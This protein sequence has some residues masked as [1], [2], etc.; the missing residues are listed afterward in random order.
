MELQP[1]ILESQNDMNT[2]DG[3]TIER[4]IRINRPDEGRGRCK[5][6]RASGR[7]KD[8]SQCMQPSTTPCMGLFPSSLSFLYSLLLR[9]VISQ[10]AA[11]EMIGGELAIG[12]V[13]MRRNRVCGGPSKDPNYDAAMRIA[14]NA[15]S[16]SG[17]GDADMARSRRR[18]VSPTCQ[19]NCYAFYSAM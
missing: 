3:A 14:K 11:V 13:S 19:Q 18:G 8:F 5:G 15:P 2:A 9:E 12:R 16:L 1:V 10:S 6:S 7:R 17:L 4:R